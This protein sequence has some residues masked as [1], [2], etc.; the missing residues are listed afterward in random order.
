[1]TARRRPT[2]LVVLAA[3]G[4][5]LAAVP[6]AHAA[7]GVTGVTTS[8]APTQAGAHA[9]YSLG[10]R[11]SDPG[12][13]VKDLT[14]HLPPGLVGNP[15]AQPVCPLAQFTAD[16]CAAAT[17]VGTSQVNADPMDLTIDG[18]IYS[19]QAQPGEPARLGIVYRNPTVA[20]MFVQSAVSLR[21]AD[22]GLDSTIKDL[23][24]QAT[25]AGLLPTDVT[26][27]GISL[28]LQSSF[29]SNPTSCGPATT[30]VDATSYAAPSTVTS[31]AAS[32]TPTGCEKVPF[33]P[34]L[35]V[36]I[37]NTGR[38]LSPAL[39]TVITQAAGEGSV[40]GAVVTLP[41]GIGPNLAGL[42]ATCTQSDAAAGSC[43][44]TTSVGTASAQT[45][46]LRDPLAGQVYL[47]APP[48]AGQLPTL[49]IDL[50][51]ALRIAL[52]ATVGISKQGRLETT[53]DD[54]P[55]V[56]LSR[57]ALSFKGTG[58]TGVLSNVE[59]LCTK[60]RPFLATFTA[61]GGLAA[62]STGNAT[63]TGCKA[64]AKPATRGPRAIATLGRSGT[65]LVDVHAGA[66]R[67]RGVRVTLARSGRAGAVSSRP[68]RARLRGRTVTVDRLAKRGTSRVVVRVRSARSAIGA[69]V[70]VSVVD[71]AGRRTAVR[72]RVRR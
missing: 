67:I 12:Q 11:F 58:T 2:V 52:K 38:G 17:A 10:F 14:I 71:S 9:A 69:R 70:T 45:P 43:P 39:S 33:A 54:I 16:Q 34:K 56:P 8:A 40:K 35:T 62:Q 68:G 47:V 51:G 63:L 57:F 4:V 18:T 37:A 48:A 53:L 64:V 24:R 49:L 44:D 20:K 66:R 32:Y 60:A 28:A 21:A 25:I 7:L 50:R 61:Q 30:R 59:D 41:D 31:G 23:P 5:S 3:V 6:S 36:S 27:K 1:M 29:I 46:L 42:G 22:G 72:A 19:I 55:D 65:L 26:V 15:L 13:Q